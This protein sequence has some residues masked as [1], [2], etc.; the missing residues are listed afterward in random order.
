MLGEH[1][2]ILLPQY[3]PKN[4]ARRLPGAQ[5]ALLLAATRSFSLLLYPAD[6]SGHLIKA[7]EMVVDYRKSSAFFMNVSL[8]PFA[9]NEDNHFS[10]PRNHVF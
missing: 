9:L 8:A 5:R 10:Q 1:A 2:Q 6:P 4:E 7:K 3:L